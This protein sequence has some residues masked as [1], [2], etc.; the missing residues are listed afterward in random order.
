VN[1]EDQE[2][3]VLASQAAEAMRRIRTLAICAWNVAN[4]GDHEPQDDAEIKLFM[5][6]IVALAEEWS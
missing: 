1:A 2:R 3:D 4:E 6:K 5:E